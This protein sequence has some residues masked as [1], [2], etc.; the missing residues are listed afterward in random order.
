MFFF[1]CL[2]I[3]LHHLMIFYFLVNLFLACFFELNF[4]LIFTFF[5]NV[6]SINVFFFW[7][8]KK[9]EGRSVKRLALSCLVFF[10]GC[11]TF[12]VM[13]MMSMTESNQNKIKLRF[14]CLSCCFIRWNSFAFFGRYALY[15][16]TPT[17]Y[18]RKRKFRMI[19]FFGRWN[20]VR[21]EFTVVSGWIVKNERKSDQS[22]RVEIS[23]LRGL[24][25]FS[26][27]NLTDRILRKQ[28]FKKLR[29]LYVLKFES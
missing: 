12:C 27:E 18:E 11:L 26:W 24:T 22:K 6:S 16:F 3:I 10:N 9:L 15:V 17:E 1:S 8:C 21:R 29:E 28:K 13:Y 20:G 4:F 5:K 25:F 7:L 23:K 14:V 19:F 2:I